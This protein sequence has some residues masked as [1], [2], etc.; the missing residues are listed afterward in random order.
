MLEQHLN[1]PK[2]NQE[3]FIDDK[4]ARHHIKVCDKKINAEDIVKL[5]LK[6]KEACKSNPHK[7]NKILVVCNKI[8]TAQNIFDD[9]K[10]LIKA[11]YDKE[12]IHIFHS[13]FIKEDRENLKKKL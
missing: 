2:E 4:K 3:V 11:K 6:N 5:Y 10:E 13:R 9:V 12:E 8:K 1:I 7:G